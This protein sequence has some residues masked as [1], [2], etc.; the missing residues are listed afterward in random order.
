MPELLL[1]FDELLD[2]RLDPDETE[3]AGDELLEPELER[4]TRAGLL[5]LL[6]EDLELVT[7]E[8]LEPDLDL[9]TFEGLLVLLLLCGRLLYPG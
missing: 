4:V 1:A 8:L 6:P 7:D 9:V 2:E 5:D 3:R